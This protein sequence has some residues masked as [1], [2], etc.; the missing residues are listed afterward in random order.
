MVFI[1]TLWCLNRNGCVAV[2]QIVSVYYNAPYYHVV[3]CDHRRGSGFVARFIAHLC[4][5][6]LHFPNQSRTQTSVLSLLQCPVV[7]YW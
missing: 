5:S 7:V 1:I 6:L 2:T 4:N 3:E